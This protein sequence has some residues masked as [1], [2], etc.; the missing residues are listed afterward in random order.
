MNNKNKLSS[1]KLS[2]NSS[3]WEQEIIEKIKVIISR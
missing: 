2:A 3:K 1:Q